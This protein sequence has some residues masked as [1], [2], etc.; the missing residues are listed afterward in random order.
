MQPVLSARIEPP[1]RTDDGSTAYRVAVWGGE[2]VVYKGGERRRKGKENSGEILG[3]E[4]V[5]EY[6]DVYL[7]GSGKRRETIAAETKST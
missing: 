4:E 3:K 5:K 7:P 6:V 1:V 2:G